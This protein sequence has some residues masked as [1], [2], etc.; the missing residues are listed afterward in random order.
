MRERVHQ[1]GGHM[2]IQSGSSGT[3]VQ[4]TL[5]FQETTVC[6]QSVS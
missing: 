6:A 5:P 4:A 1:L 2:E 3:R